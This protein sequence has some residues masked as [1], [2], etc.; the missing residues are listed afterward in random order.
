MLIAVQQGH[1]KVVAMWMHRLETMT[2]RNA[3]G[4]SPLHAAAQLN[5]LVRFEFRKFQVRMCLATSIVV[6][7][8][9]LLI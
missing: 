6:D 4:W 3:A 5:H 8:R 7:C 9:K 2:T 1:V